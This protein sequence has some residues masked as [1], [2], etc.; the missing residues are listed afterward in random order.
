MKKL[1]LVSLVLFITLSFTGR[2]MNKLGFTSHR[3]IAV[4]QNARGIDLLKPPAPPPEVF[5]QVAPNDPYL[6]SQWNLDD[7]GKAYVSG[8]GKN[9]ITVYSNHGIQAYKAWKLGYSGNGVKIA[10]IGYGIAYKDLDINGDGTLDYYLAPNLATTK[11]DYANA[12]DFSVDPSNPTPYPVDC[13]GWGTFICGLMAAPTNDGYGIA[14]IAYKATILPLK[15]MVCPG[16]DQPGCTPLINS[17]YH[18]VASNADIIYISNWTIFDAEIMHTA[19]QYAV[20]NGV[21]VICSCWPAGLEYPDAIYP[22]AYDE[23][24]AVGATNFAGVPT[25][26]SPYGEWLDLI[27]PA[28]LDSEDLNHYAANDS[29]YSQIVYPDYPNQFAFVKQDFHGVSG[30]QVAAVVALMLEKNPNLTPAQVKT[31]LTSTAKHDD[32]VSY[33][34]ST[35]GYGLVDAYGALMATPNP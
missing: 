2:E 26:N 22:A 1:M 34:N 7:Y 18:A 33:P 10:Y 8:T 24:I 32:G 11:F 27:A 25:V 28:G 16:Q 9:K 4:E 35:Y 23:V 19:I 21:V 20:N 5:P 29:M 6:G 15:S 3:A 12:R 13:H 14:G 17:I 30:A 31:I